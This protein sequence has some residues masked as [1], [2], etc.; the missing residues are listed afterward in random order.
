MIKSEAKNN[1]K[2]IE[3]DEKMVWKRSTSSLKELAISRTSLNSEK[4]VNNGTLGDPEEGEELLKELEASSKGKVRGS[5]YLHY[6]KS[7]KRPWTLAVLFVSVLL[8]QALASVA[9][10]WVAYW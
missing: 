3:R 4:S 2:S 1:D 6:L 7:A 8:S 5:V 10:V 9:D